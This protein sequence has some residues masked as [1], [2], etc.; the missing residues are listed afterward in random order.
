MYHS[1]K[2]SESLCGDNSYDEGQEKAG[3][4]RTHSRRRS[5][6]SRNIHL[7]LLFSVFLNGILA[8]FLLKNKHMLESAERSK[9]GVY[10]PQYLVV[11]GD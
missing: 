4:A 2:S 9:F 11:N 7:V 1:L 5:S 6:S 10:N 3:I 8:G